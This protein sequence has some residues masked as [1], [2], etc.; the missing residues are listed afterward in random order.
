[1]SAHGFQTEMYGHTPA[2]EPLYLRFSKLAYALGV[3]HQKLA[4]SAWGLTIF[5]LGQ[6]VA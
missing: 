5:A 6:V 3:L 2:P 1:M 4:P